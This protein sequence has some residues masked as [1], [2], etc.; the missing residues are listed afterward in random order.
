MFIRWQTKQTV[1]GTRSIAIV[2]EST[3]VDG[4]PRPRHIAYL[5]HIWDHYGVNG[6]IRF[7]E[8]ATAKLDS[9]NLTAADRRKLEKA[10]VLRIPRPTRR[11]LKAADRAFQ[12]AEAGLKGLGLLRR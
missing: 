10:L 3:R 1:D 5:G 8:K 11:E 6:R 9:L 4:K 7:W 12:E 2:A